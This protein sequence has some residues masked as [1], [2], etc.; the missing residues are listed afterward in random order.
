MLVV[1]I[2]AAVPHADVYGEPTDVQQASTAVYGGLAVVQQAHRARH[3][4]S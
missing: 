4:V 3:V 1:V 2:V